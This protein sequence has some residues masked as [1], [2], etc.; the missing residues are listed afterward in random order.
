MN[1]FYV[2]FSAIPAR[3]ASSIHI[4]KICQAF[5]ENGHN[6]T[7]IAP[8]RAD[9]TI[10]DV[11]PAIINEFYNVKGDFTFIKLS[12]PKVKGW[13]LLYPFYVA[14]FVGKKGTVFTRHAEVAAITTLF[15]IPTIIE[16]HHTEYRG[17]F[18]QRF[19]YKKLFRSPYLLKTVVIS[20]VLKEAFIKRNMKAGDLL[21]AHDGSDLP[22]ITTKMVF[23]NTEFYKLEAGYVGQLYKGKG[24]EVILNIADKLPQVR[25]HIVGGEE[26]DIAKWKEKTDKLGANNIIFHGFVPQTFISKYIN[27]FDVC[28][29]PNQKKVSFFGNSSINIGE[30]TSPLKMFDYMAHGKPIIASDLPVLREVLNEN[31]AILCNPEDSECWIN[32]V[33]KLVS[34]DAFGKKLGENALNDF[35]RKYTWKKRAEYIIDNITIAGDNK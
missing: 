15:N 14:K 21:V 5:A 23:E 11:S 31:N 13:K 10:K 34:D 19:L 22:T 33:N 3:T 20:D 18:I 6:V 7:L 32:A 2:T 16:F 8:D 4:M 29:L 35:V 1:I 12:T 9:N 17:N 25:F 24:V 30:F 27:A 26:A 28:L